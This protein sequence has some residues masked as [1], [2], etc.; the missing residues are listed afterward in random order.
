[1]H[2]TNIIT[3]PQ[4]IFLCFAHINENINIIT[5]QLD[6]Q[7]NKVLLAAAP[8]VIILYPCIMAVDVLHK[9]IVQRQIITIIT[10][11]TSGL[12]LSAS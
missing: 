1:M 3:P 6:K 7:H 10:Y 9:N 11:H 8:L 5:I 2:R 4:I 12:Q